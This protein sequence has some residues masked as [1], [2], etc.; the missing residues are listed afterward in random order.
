MVG[1]GGA[2]QGGLGCG[3]L[4]R[5]TGGW[6]MMGDERSLEGGI[7]QNHTHNG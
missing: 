5:S 6:D 4:G 1:D 7:T 3:G 2:G